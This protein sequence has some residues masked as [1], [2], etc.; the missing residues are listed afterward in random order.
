MTQKYTYRKR[1]FKD[2]RYHARKWLV[3]ACL[4]ILLIGS[5]VWYVYQNT[6]QANKNDSG[7]TSGVQTQIISDNSIIYTTAYFKFQDTGAKWVREPDQHNNPNI[8]IYDKFSGQ[9]LLGEMIFYINQE[10]NTLN[11][12]TRVLPV[13]LVNDNSFEVTGVSDPCVS[14]YAPNEAKFPKTIKFNGA[15]MKCNPTT[16]LYTVIVSQIGGDYHLRLERSNGSPIQFEITLSLNGLDPSTVNFREI[17]NSF[18][19]L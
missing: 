10:A 2:S 5:G 8:F 12:F 9:T 14:Q 6:K 13:R 18:Q 19:A 4:L 16:G 11:G 3:V 15:L 7:V 17:I 1:V